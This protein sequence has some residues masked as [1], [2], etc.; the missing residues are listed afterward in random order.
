MKRFER[1]RKDL[2]GFERFEQQKKKKTD[3]SLK[4]GDGK[5]QIAGCSLEILSAKDLKRLE[6]MGKDLKRISQDLKRFEKI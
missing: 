2:K 1:V 4:A 5:L 6:R 3:L